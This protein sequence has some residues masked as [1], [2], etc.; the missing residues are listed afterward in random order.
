MSDIRYALYT[1]T[2]ELHAAGRSAAEL[3]DI[4]DAAALA[5]ALSQDRDA[6]RLEGYADTAEQAQ[7]WCD[8]EP[9]RVG[10]SD[11]SG[12]NF[13][14]VMY[15]CAVPEEYDEDAEIYEPSCDL[16]ELYSRAD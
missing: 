1:C 7:T 16:D 15:R 4:S 6:G 11:Y 2:S 10:H 9:V 5:A 3:R 8:A 14:T 12:A 13:V